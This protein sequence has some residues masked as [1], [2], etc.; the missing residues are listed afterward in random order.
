MPSLEASA[1]G[2]IPAS[3]QGFAARHASAR[4][5]GFALAHQHQRHVSQRREVARRSYAALRRHHRRDAALQHL[6]QAFRHHRADAGKAFRQHVG[7]DQHHG[8]HL[9]ALER[10][11]RAGGMRANH[12][13]LQLLE[14]GRRHAHIRQQADSCVDAVDGLVARRQPL[15]HRARP[16]HF[17]DGCRSQ[18]GRVFVDRDGNHLF[19][20]KAVAI[21]YDHTSCMVAKS[22]CQ[23]LGVR[24]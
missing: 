20:G 5:L 4:E 7:A 2:S 18:R 14:V 12:V 13:A 16:Q 21:Q 10:I 1:S 19:D 23:V 3:A 24:C 9:F 6:A 17:F 15:D 22:R 11:A 8:P